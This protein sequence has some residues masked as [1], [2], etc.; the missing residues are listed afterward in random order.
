MLKKLFRRRRVR[1][2]KRTTF[3]RMF[4]KAMILPVIVTMLIGG[5]AFLMLD[6]EELY[7]ELDSINAFITQYEESTYSKKTNSEKRIP[8]EVFM[9]LYGNIDTFAPYGYLNPKGWVHPTCKSASFLFDNGG[10]IIAS[11]RAKFIVDISWSE[12][13]KDDRYYS[14]DPTEYN[15]PE[16]TKV[17]N[18]AL[19]KVDDYTTCETDISSLYINKTERKMIPHTM[20]VRLVKQDNGFLDYNWEKSITTL[21]EYYVQIDADIDGYELLVLNKNGYPRNNDDIGQ[22]EGLF[23]CDPAEFDELYDKCGESLDYY[24]SKRHMGGGFGD[25]VPI[26]THLESC[27]IKRIVTSLDDIS[28]C[29]YLDN[30]FS[31]ISSWGRLIVVLA[32]LLGFM[33][34]IAF[35]RCWSR[36][37]KN[38]AQYAFED[39]Q[40]SLIN[41]L[42]HDLKTPLAVIGGYAENLQELRK[43]SGS[44][45]ELKYINS[46]MNNV[47]YTDDIIA[48]TLELSENEQ[49]KKPNKTNV[50]IKALTERLL[51]KYRAALDE[52]NIELKTELGGEVSAD[53]DVLAAAVENLISNAVKYT[54]DDGFIT[55]TADSKR[56][57]IVN[58]VSVN[59]DTK[60]LLMPFAKGD[61]AR[62]DKRSHGLGLAI[63]LSAAER[64][65]F[66]L[67]VSCKEK[68]FTAT[69][70]F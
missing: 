8:D 30:D 28:L 4:A 58:D 44:E 40:R 50:D 21:E 17:Y 12:D 46:I 56:L 6:I 38:K 13:S 20:R 34:I 10:N 63:A 41:N 2:P 14:C 45:K 5:Y 70:R 61:K 65:G 68:K 3:L 18:D 1:K 16:L 24:L 26:N 66:A 7:I 29:V 36:S 62:S 55:V 42:A 35:I 31:H 37:I 67:S 33:T 43:D 32:K 52:R 53:E 60:D 19:S 25:A 11:N 9:S 54:R 51:D 57:S 64:N 48:K 22:H 49:M 39:Y 27:T 23:G 15:I 69:I 59:V 47:S